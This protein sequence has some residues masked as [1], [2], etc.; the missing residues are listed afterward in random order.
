MRGR[1]PEEQVIAGRSCGNH[2]D[3]GAAMQRPQASSPE[4]RA[5]RLRRHAVV[6][7]VLLLVFGLT[8]FFVGLG[9]G[10]TKSGLPPERHPALLPQKDDLSLSR[11]RPTRSP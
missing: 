10:I 9:T 1:R 11:D 6:F 2:A 8:T 5:P 7:G 3:N 4:R